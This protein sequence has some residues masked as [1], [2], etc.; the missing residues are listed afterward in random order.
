ML[1]APMTTTSPLDQRLDIARNNIRMA[2]ALR[3]MNFAEIAR[4]AGLS[5]NAV[6]QFVAGRTSLSYQ[7]MLRVC[8]VLGVP[9]GLMH[10]A[11]S[12][13]EARIRLHK[14]LTSL[15]EHLA[16]EAFA[17]VAEARPRRRESD[18]DD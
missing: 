10:Q 3:N 5:R 11:D 16:S 18:P 2:A 9:I 15:P 1:D 8:D 17:A 4:A 6:S 13:T 7:N 14:A 12:I